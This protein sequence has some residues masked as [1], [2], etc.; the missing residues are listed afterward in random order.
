MTEQNNCAKLHNDMTYH[1]ALEF[2]E[3]LKSSN[4]DPFQFMLDMQ[5]DLQNALHKKNPKY[6]PAPNDLKTI[7]QKFDWLRENKQA[8][9][10]EYREIIDALPGILR[11][12]KD[13]SA[14]W[15]RW[16]QKYTE[17][18]ALTFNDL[19]QEELKELK[20]EL[21]DAFHFFMNMFFAL[22]MTAQEMFIYYYF[23]NAE[24]HSRAINGY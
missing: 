4:K 17:I 16:K 7:G 3:N 1:K 11:P 10:D 5:Y 24:N 15:K 8:F 14:V 21:T 9:D 20:Y 18:R 6:N 12:A 23:K 22:D 13:R 19:T 2:Y